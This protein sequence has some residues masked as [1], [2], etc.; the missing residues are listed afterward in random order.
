VGFHSQQDSSL[1]TGKLFQ[2]QKCYEARN[3]SD[4][5]T[6][7]NCVKKK[8]TGKNASHPD[9]RLEFETNEMDSRLIV[10]RSE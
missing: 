8:R 10:T 6:K 9:N 2:S 4:G 5:R 3:K 7:E 1:Q